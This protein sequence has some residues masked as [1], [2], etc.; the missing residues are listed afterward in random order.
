MGPIAHTVDGTGVPSTEAS[1]FPATSS[2]PAVH[3][4]DGVCASGKSHAAIE[5]IAPRIGAGERWLIAGPTTAQCRQFAADLTQR[6][7]APRPWSGTACVHLVNSEDHGLADTSTMF[8]PSVQQTLAQTVEALPDGSGSAIIITHA[9]LLAL[10]RSE[11]FRTWRLLI[12]EAPALVL[13]EEI[14][15]PNATWK[16]MQFQGGNGPTD[17]IRLQAEPA[18]LKAVLRAA[19]RVESELQKLARDAETRGRMLQAERLEAEAVRLRAEQ[20]EPL[21]TLQ[22][23]LR[24]GHWMILPPRRMTEP[25]MGDDHAI[26]SHR[27]RLS[28]GRSA[29]IVLISQLD[30][31]AFLG[32]NRRRWQSVTL[33]AANAEHSLAVHSLHKQGISVLEESAI[34][35]RLRFRD[36]H[37]NGHR[38]TILYATSRRLMSRTLWHRMAG[39]ETYGQRI[40]RAVEQEFDGRPFC[41]SANADVPDD[42]LAGKRMPAVAH[43]LNRF[44]AYDHVAAL[45]LMN[46]SPPC[47]AALEDAGFSAEVVR[48]AVALESVYQAVCRSSIRDLPSIRPVTVIVPDQDAAEF[49]AARFPGCRVAPL[50]LEEPAEFDEAAGSL[51]ARDIATT[52]KHARPI[53]ALRQSILDNASE[54]ERRRL[55]AVSGVSHGSSVN[56]RLLRCGNEVDHTGRAFRCNRP[57]CP[58]CGEKKRDEH[59]KA[60]LLPR[61]SAA[62]AQGYTIAHLTVILPPTNNIGEVSKLLGSAKRKLV[63]CRTRLAK[64]HPSGLTFSADG[65][66][67]IAMV[68]AN[69][70]DFVSEGR[71]RTLVELGFPESACGG[72][73]WCPHLHLVLLAPPGQ[74]LDAIGGELRRIFDAPR[75]VHIE[76]IPT[77]EHF[78]R[79]V[80]RVA[81]YGAKF[82]GRTE[83]VSPLQRDWSPAEM[84][85]A[86]D[87]SEKASAKGM[88][89]VTIQLGMRAKATIAAGSNADADEQP[90]TA[91]VSREPQQEPSEAPPMS[92]NT[93]TLPTGLPDSGLR[94]RHGGPFDHARSSDKARLKDEADMPGRLRPRGRKRPSHPISLSASPAT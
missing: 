38:V 27:L 59:T 31:R 70:L 20:I 1:S 74:S 15:L 42:A 18:R 37:P 71:R 22:R 53:A 56:Q 65:T 3:I 83:V 33:M 5:E 64:T 69:Q 46:L 54:H 23:R 92:L 8:R 50:G 84:A 47:I 94:D 75:Q 6:L 26:R 76:E 10:P 88:R 67:E 32:L 87:W 25:V 12:D 2:W 39:G 41:W 81:R 90:V 52:A 57:F 80:F 40:L 45:A 34:S 11:M 7:N 61:C 58:R 16:T 9:T 17:P 44:Q 51:V 78:V 13:A 29:R 62:L 21:Q 86:L 89:G 4:V 48:R 55:V 49:V 91:S 43:G 93:H 63:G 85:L 60:M 66:L 14:D 35:E 77:N 79:S 68:P 73:V 82:V 30:W 24:S 19:S 72:P 36:A 28:S